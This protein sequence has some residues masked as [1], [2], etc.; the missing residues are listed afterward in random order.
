[1][2]STAQQTE[3]PAIE[4][5]NLQQPVDAHTG[6]QPL[7]TTSLSS[8]DFSY[9]RNPSIDDP[10]DPPPA[11]VNK[12]PP[13]SPAA[14]KPTPA[15]W[16]RLKRTPRWVLLALALT[17][18]AAIVIPVVLV[19]VVERRKAQALVDALEFREALADGLRLST[20]V[21]V[22]FADAD[23][24]SLRYVD[25]VEYDGRDFATD[26]FSVTLYME[27]V[28]DEGRVLGTAEVDALQWDSYRV[29]FDCGGANV[30][31]GD[32]AR[33]AEVVRL[34]R[35]LMSEKEVRVVSK[36]TAKVN[37]TKALPKFEVEWNKTLTFPGKFYL[38]FA[39]CDFPFFFLAFLFLGDGEADVPLFNYR[40]LARDSI[41][42][43]K[44]TCLLP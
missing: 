34:L 32:V 43:W 11:Y 13:Y 16:E 38:S 2:A 15:L 18:A 1:M 10:S 41:S 8:A 25:E 6:Q 35:R 7:D 40:A 44:F 22:S 3:H 21:S 33:D 28:V 26:G 37:W 9:H 14:A 17:A 5:G 30:R 4:L 42:C 39:E 23:H 20:N 31:G 24:W 12:P 19:F 29:N 36:G 27:D